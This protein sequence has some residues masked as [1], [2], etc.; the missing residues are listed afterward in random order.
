MQAQGT[1]HLHAPSIAP[2]TLGT[3]RMV[4]ESLVA[5]TTVQGR[6]RLPKKISSNVGKP[7]GSGVAGV[8]SLW[9]TAGDL[10]GPEGCFWLNGHVEP[11]LVKAR[12]ARGISDLTDPGLCYRSDYPRRGEAGKAW[13]GS[14]KQLSKY[15]LASFLFPQFSL[16]DRLSA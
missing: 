5:S 16:P 8:R 3:R 15:R 7:V 14:Q 9:R 1:G 6:P 11:E 13:S 12:A 4:L 2:C 10:P